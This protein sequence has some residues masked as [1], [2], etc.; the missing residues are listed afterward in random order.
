MKFEFSIAL[1]TLACL[2]CASLPYSARC[3]ERCPRN[4][5]LGG[6]SSSL[7]HSRDSGM[8]TTGDYRDVMHEQIA[9]ICARPECRVLVASGDGGVHLGFIAGEPS[10]R[11]VYYCFVKDLY[12]RHGVSRALFAELGVDPRARF[13]YPCVT[14]MA[15]VLAGKV[16]FAVHDPAVARYPKQER[17]RSYAA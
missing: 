15:K 1:T 17:H 2:A 3:P 10:E 14:R 12:R 8:I 4:F 13:A 9:K 11:V 5:V 7:H 16:P 6:W